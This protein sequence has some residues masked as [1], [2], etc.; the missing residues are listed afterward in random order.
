MERSSM[1]SRVGR[2]AVVVGAGIGGLSAAGAL[3]KHFDEVVV[4]ER[5]RLAK[6]AGSRR[7]T[8]QD[9]HPHAL[10]AGGQQALDEIFPGFAMD[11]VRAGAVRIQLAQDVRYERAD[12]GALP[13]R[14]LGLSLLGASRPLIEFVLRNRAMAIAN[15]G[16]RTECR[17]TEIVPVAAGAAVRGVRF[18]AASGGSEM[19]EADL[20]VDASGR[21]ALTSTLL[22]LLG[23]QRPEE[24]E[25]SVD[26]TTS[27]VVV[28]IPADAPPD[29]KFVL[30][31]PNPPTLALS[32]VL[33]PVE[34][35]RWVVSVA[36]R[37]ASALPE[38]WE[39]FLQAL[40]GLI[41][42]TLYNALS[43]AKP[44]ERIRNFNF[45]ASLWR[46][47][48]RLPCLP[49]GVPPIADALCRFNPVYGQ[50]MSA[51]A[52]QARLLQ[53]VLGRAA[54]EPD[55]VAASQAGF[56]AEVG[57][58]LQTPWN[59][60]TSADLAFPATRGERPKNFAESR[61]FEAALFRAVIADPFVHRAVMAVGQLLQPHSLLGEPEIM[62]RVE[63]V[64]AQ[65]SR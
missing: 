40:R 34:D 20:V 32:A 10:L 46:H 63:A 60:S 53:E 17:V 5:D 59:M 13:Q 25:I 16:L 27:A 47:F 31:L 15:I 8:A 1:N 14:D 21:G 62:R 12:V 43:H 49:R 44:P 7:G 23:L 65:T 55:P 2:R 52:K 24:T 45:P 50:G 61:Q 36:Q 19:L 26:I 38:T 9:G 29:W 18:D 48:E 28:S 30:T 11:L 39:D 41:T 51:A 64:S 4:L 42:P 54:A 58:V 22:N 33:I 35:S 6:S 57:S 3:A 56:M 37:G